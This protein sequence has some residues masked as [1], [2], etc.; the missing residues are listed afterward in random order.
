[1]AREIIINP[2]DGGIVFLSCLFGSE[3]VHRH[4]SFL[5]IPANDCRGAEDRA[6]QDAKAEAAIHISMQDACGAATYNLASKNKGRAL[7]VFSIGTLLGVQL[8][9]DNHTKALP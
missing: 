9:N 3:Q 6:T 5:V 7:A 1:M 2:N 4:S 8:Q